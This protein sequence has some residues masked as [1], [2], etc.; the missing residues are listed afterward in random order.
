MRPNGFLGTALAIA[1]VAFILQIHAH[2][3]SLRYTQTQNT[4]TAL[5][6]ERVQVERSVLEYTTDHLLREIVA[7]ELARA[8][9][10]DTI[11]HHTAR[12]LYHAFTQIEQNN[13]DIRFYLAMVNESN[14]LAP[15]R[16]E[17]AITENDLY[18]ILSVLVLNPPDAPALAQLEL[19]G[20]AL[21]NQT[22]CGRIGIGQSEGYFLIP[23]HYRQTVIG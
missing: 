17:H 12:R 4:L 19:A 18:E 13:P 9:D 15:P 16:I 7:D 20:G 5:E 3:Q 22:V 11:R 14:Y 6:L 2:Q 1:F 23:I 21:Q 10:A 8:T